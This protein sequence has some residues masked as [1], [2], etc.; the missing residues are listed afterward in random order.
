MITV[1]NP[2]EGNMDAVGMQRGVT[3]ISRMAGLARGKRPCC[4]EVRG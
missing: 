2:A 1:T 3:D 4:D